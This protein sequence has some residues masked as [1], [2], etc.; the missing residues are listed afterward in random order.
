MKNSFKILILALVLIICA[1]FSACSGEDFTSIG[2]PNLKFENGGYVVNLSSTN[3]KIDVSSY[4][5]VSENATF[6]VSKSDNFEST[7]DTVVDLEEGENIL[8]IKVKDKNGNETVYKFN[9]IRKKT[10]NVVFKLND[11]EFNKIQCEQGM[12]IEAPKS[13]D[14]GYSINWDFD[15]SNPILEDT[16]INGTLVPN[17]YKITVSAEGSD[18]HNKEITVTYGTKPSIDTPVKNGYKF[19]GWIYKDNMSFDA[20]A[21]YK[22]ASD[23]TIQAVFEIENYSINYQ[24]NGG[25]NNSEN[26]FLYNIDTDTIE[27]KAPNWMDDTYVFDGWYLDAEFNN[28]I[29]KIEKGSFGSITLFAKWKHVEFKT[30]VTISAPGLDFD[31]AKIELTYGEVYDLTE[32]TKNGYNLVSW[33][34]SIGKIPNVGVWNIKNTELTI[35]P[36]YS[37]ILYTIIYKGLNGGD[38]SAN[39]TVFT[40]EDEITLND[41]VWSDGSYTFVG[42]FL[43]EALTTQIEGIEKNT[44]NDLVLYAKCEIVSKEKITEVTLSAPDFEDFTSEKLNIKYG[45]SYTLPQLN[46]EGYVFKGWE[47]EDGTKHFDFSGVWSCEDE[48]ITLVP[49]FEIEEY[50]I[51]YELNGGENNPLNP[52]KYTIFDAVS[53][54]DPNWINDAYVFDGWFVDKELTTRF[55]SFEAGKS[56]AITVYAK[57]INTT[58][59]TIKAPGFDCDGEEIKVVF[60][61]DYILP[62][63]SK[64]GYSLDAWKTEDG[65]ILV[66]NSGKW[67]REETSITIEPVWSLQ[68]FTITYILNGGTNNEGNVVK[69]TVED[70]VT[71]LL[72]TKEYADFSGWYLESTFVNKIEQ[73]SG[74]YSDITLYAKWEVKEFTVS[75]N[76]NG[77]TVSSNAVTVVYG[78]AYELPI[79]VLP[80]Y[81]FLGWFDGETAVASEGVWLTEAGASLVAK[82][83]K[84]KYTIEYELN[85]GEFITGAPKT[86]YTIDDANFALPTPFKQGYI[87]LGWSSDDGIIRKT[88][89]I[90]KGSYGDRK[91]TANWCDEKD[92]IGF[93][94]NISSDGTA[95]IVGFTGTVGNLVIPSEYNGH[96]VTSI[97]NNAFNGYGEK[98]ASLSN[99]SSFVTIYIPTTITRIGVDAFKNCTDLKIQVSNAKDSEVEEWL[100]RVIIESGNAQVVDVIRNVRPAIGWNPYKK[101]KS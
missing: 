67:M 56:G 75:L 95:S 54:L 37:A 52:S 86:Q 74:K 6:V 36:E 3:N 17:E 99:N 91:Y 65:S 85:G 46:I 59:I 21:E 27:L 69:F 13:V 31:G 40:V 88:L 4:F 32:Y 9:F 63:V 101:P 50:K 25:N 38:N 7:I 78:S 100:S 19:V 76:G 42:W 1:I 94:Y 80:G 43:D 62:S 92:E 96:K 51:A 55:E 57:W 12:L 89:T 23:I 82:W 97:D 81:N 39:P 8:Y 77:G 71:L 58:K 70:E 73:F 33:N 20:E 72:P 48:Y 66:Q 61:A 16:V 10:L 18:L 2:T 5:S 84:A 11:E 35:E 87:F 24:L 45:D 22:I 30:K 29:E 26:P 98:I 93:M 83:E 49:S 34:S 14:Q 41:L 68:T 44:T 64:N 28:L 79:P 53:L 47:T 15:F 60:G 90:A